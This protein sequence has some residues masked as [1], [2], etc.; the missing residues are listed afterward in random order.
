MAKD[1]TKAINA[2]NDI[3][4]EIRMRD[5]VFRCLLENPEYMNII[6]KK[7]VDDDMLERLLEA[8][9]SIFQYIKH[10]SQRIIDVGLM[11]DGGNIWHLKK[12]VRKSLST[13]SLMKALNSNP[14]QV[15]KCINKDGRKNYSSDTME[16]YLNYA[17]QKIEETPNSIQFISNPTEEMK[18]LAISKDPNVALYFDKLSD[19]MMDIIDEK[20]PGL[21]SSLPNYTREIK[22]I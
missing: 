13:D 19:K 15:M 12:K 14:D 17:M 10:P 18:C 4:H 5:K 22:N 20:Y 3:A 8:D 16:S 6:K 21:R 2:A 7:Y 1:I 9:P 11:L